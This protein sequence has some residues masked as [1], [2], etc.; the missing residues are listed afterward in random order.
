M[1][2]FPMVVIDELRDSPPEMALSDRNHSVEA[3][4]F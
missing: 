1:I 3:L 4:F 2:P